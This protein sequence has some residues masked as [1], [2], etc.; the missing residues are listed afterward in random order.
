MVRML[1]R[2]RRRFE[3][4]WKRGPVAPARA[5]GAAAGA[6]CLIAALLI[7]GT[8]LCPASG[9]TPRAAG[10]GAGVAW[11]RAA[12]ND[13][14]GFGF[15]PGEDV[16]PGDDRLGGAR[17]GGGRDQPARPRS[18]RRDAD[19][20]PGGDRRRDHHHRRH[21]AHDPRSCAAPASTRGTSGATTWSAACWPGAASDGSWGGQVNQTAFGILAL[22]AAGTTSGQ[23][24]LGGLAAGAPELGWRLGIRRRREQR[25]GHHRRGAAGAWPRPAARPGSGGGSRTCAGSSD[26]AA[27]SR[28][29]GG[30]INAQSTAY[31]VQGL[32]AAGVAALGGPQGRSL[33]ARLPRLRPGRRRPLPLLVLERP[34]AGLG[35][36]PG[37]AGGQR[38][39]LPARARCRGES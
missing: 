39:R 13:D 15:A 22:Q 11:L 35:D 4:A 36:R 7:A 17:P 10:S 6:A 18:R 29:T 20:L 31:A 38:R 21:R 32:V 8:V 5:G 9:R 23:W 16:E 19:L 2:Y 34:D 3:F 24:P 33:P 14:G 12:Q 27:G 28:S 30:V 25:R 1:L 26:P 37:P